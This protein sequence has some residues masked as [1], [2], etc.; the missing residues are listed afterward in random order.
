MPRPATRWRC[1]WSRGAGCAKD[2]VEAWAW[3]ALAA[4]RGSG[5]AAANRDRL[6][7]RLSA[8]QRALAEMR[9]VALR[10]EGS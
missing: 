10:A 1:C 4:E 7:E 2:P 8:E 6:G 9:L 3:F 5:F